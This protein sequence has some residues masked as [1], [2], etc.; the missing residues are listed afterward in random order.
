MASQTFRSRAQVVCGLGLDEAL[1]LRGC[2]QTGKQG[3][4]G[5]SFQ[6]QLMGPRSLV[7]AGCKVAWLSWGVRYCH[8]R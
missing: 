4:L 6:C 3:A 8:A 5:Q 7:Q 2:A 1:N